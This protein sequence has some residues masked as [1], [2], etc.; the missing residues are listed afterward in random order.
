[1]APDR[2]RWKTVTFRRLVV[3]TMV[4]LALFPTPLAHATAPS[5]VRL[6]GDAVGGVGFGTKQVRATDELAG[7]FGSLKTANLKAIGWCGLTAQSSRRDVLLNFERGRFVGYELGNASGKLGGQ[8][9]VVT[10]SGLRLDD[11][12][13]QAEKIYGQQFIT[14]AAQG[15]SWKVKT[16]TGE[17]YGLLVSPP[18]SGSTDEIDLI[19]AGDFGCAAMG[20]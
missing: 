6:L 7:M 1:M 8:P 14:S 20:P 3:V 2:G 9:A 10:A 18:I 15:G 17:L 13:A 16:P 5:H 11:T 4:S 12:I 19:G